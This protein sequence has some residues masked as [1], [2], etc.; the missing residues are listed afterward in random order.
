MPDFGVLLDERPVN[1]GLAW[2]ATGALVLA[3]LVLLAGGEWLWPAFALVTTA[4]VVLPPVLSRDPAT[5]MP[6]ELVALVALPI[7]AR[8]AGLFSQVTPFV[9]IAGLALLVVLVLDGYTSLEMAPRF[10]VAF[11][12]VTTMAFAGFLAVGEFAADALLGTDFVEGQREM[13]V[14]LLTATVVG[15]IAG[16]AFETYFRETDGSAPLRGP[17]RATPSATETAPH[18][19]RTDRTGAPGGRADESDPPNETAPDSEVDDSAATDGVAASPRYRLAIRTLQFVLVGIVGY[20]LVTLNGK[21]FVN[22]AVPLALTFLPAV[23][24]HQYGYP[25]HARLA[26]LVSLAA[27]L[28]A[29]GALGPYTATDWYDTVTHALSSTLVAGVGYAV[30][31]GLDLHSDRVSFSPRFRAAFVV[32]FVLAVGVLWELLEF[33]SG[34]LTALFGE[35]VLAQ[36]GVED[37]VKDLVFN[38]VGALLVALWGTALFRRPARALAGHVGG[39]LR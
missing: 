29:I 7:G 23:V 20:S 27:A 22:S 26:L 16:V 11:V 3:A 35:P 39:L 32:L 10:A 6:G 37:I 18:A 4:V 2:L 9:A 13:N 36:Y 1:A 38:V 30:A 17:R 12:V 19:G 33:G 15:L 24:R 14:D 5:T 28:H 25:M 31:R 8:A 21:L 34:L